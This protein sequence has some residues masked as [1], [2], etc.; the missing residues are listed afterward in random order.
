MVDATNYPPRS[1]NLSDL[2]PQLITPKFPKVPQ[3]GRLL[4]KLQ[5]FGK[6]PLQLLKARIDQV[7]V[8]DAD[9]AHL[10]CQL[11]PAQCPFER[12]IKVFGKVLFHI[13]PM[14]KL[15]PF[16]EQVVF[17]RFRALCYL[18]DECG[19]DVGQYC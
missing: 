10:L 8:Q 19:E 9:L 3:W 6:A 15:N 4:Q 12:D 5:D 7:E 18:A 1:I 17:L 13:P 14:C 16:Y 2:S 11:I